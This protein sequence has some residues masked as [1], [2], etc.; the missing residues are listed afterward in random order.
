MQLVKLPKEARDLADPCKPSYGKWLRPDGST[1]VINARGLTVGGVEQPHFV[2]DTEVGAIRYWESGNLREGSLYSGQLIWDAGEAWTFQK[3]TGFD[4][5]PD[6]FER[7]NCP[8]SFLC[9]HAVCA[10]S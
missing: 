1:V 6:V 4:I 8:F 5:A 7:L 3:S 10:M 9:V 2:N